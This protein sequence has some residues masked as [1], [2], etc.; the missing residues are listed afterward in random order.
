MRRQ[1]V[2]VHESVPVLE[3][4]VEVGG[5]RTKTLFWC[6][7]EG[8]YVSVLTQELQGIRCVQQK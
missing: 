6:S 1:L 4:G 5:V 2:A 3:V 8:L 7:S